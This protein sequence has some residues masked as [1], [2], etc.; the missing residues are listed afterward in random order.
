MT[1]SRVVVCGMYLSVILLWLPSGSGAVSTSQLCQGIGNELWL[2]KRTQ[3]QDDAYI[4]KLL[5]VKQDCPQLSGSMDR[6]VNDIKAARQKIQEGKQHLRD[7]CEAAKAAGLTGHF[8]S[9][10]PSSAIN[11]PP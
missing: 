11:C 10:T 5:K 4:D 1:I 6:M 3:P 7:H 2:Q 9:D 8:P